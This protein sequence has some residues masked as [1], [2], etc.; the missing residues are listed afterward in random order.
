MIDVVNS[1][2]CRKKIDGKFHIFVKIIARQ[3]GEYYLGKWEDRKQL[4]DEFSQLED[5]KIIPTKNRGPDLQTQWTVAL[6]AH[7]LW[8]KEPAL[9]DYLNPNLERCMEHEINMCE[10]VKQN[11]H[12]NLA[13]Y[14]GCLAVD[15][16]AAGL[17]FQHYQYTLLE[18]VNPQ[19][20]SKRH[21]IASGRPAVRDN[22][23]CW[24]ESLRAA[25]DH[26]H[27]LGLVHNDITPA[28]VMFDEN[29]CPVLIDFGGVCRSGASL[30]YTKR[31][32]GWHD[33]NV[34]SASRSNDL[35]ALAELE[36]WLFGSVQDLQFCG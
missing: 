31:T 25:I 10:L 8:L 14:H 5:L 35:D 9:E 30:K 33:E 29:E 32:I 2:E 21:F 7:G 11:P 24:T 16:K 28:N 3:D 12:P 1:Y 27:S 15:G 18:K 6:P 17:L 19:R 22:M 34:S 23:K 36:A 4:P 20:L 26:L 13:L